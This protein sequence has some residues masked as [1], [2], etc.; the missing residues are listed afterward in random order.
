MGVDAERGTEE[1]FT[2]SP[3][4]AGRYTLAAEYE[5]SIHDPRVGNAIDELEVVVTD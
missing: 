3:P 5:E 2:W 4:R 1:A